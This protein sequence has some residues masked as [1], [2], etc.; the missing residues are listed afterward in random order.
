MPTSM[1][2]KLLGMYH[3]HGRAIWHEGDCFYASGLRRTGRLP[4]SSQ[5]SG[6]LA[7][8]E[9]VGVPGAFYAPGSRW[10]EVNDAC[11]ECVCLG[12]RSYTCAPRLCT[13]LFLCPSGLVPT[14]LAGDC[15]PSLCTRPRLRERT[16]F[17]PSGPASLPPTK[18]MLFA[19]CLIVSASLDSIL[20]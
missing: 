7:A 14:A 15:C 20:S 6:T 19:P 9:I 3:V 8:T 2:A 5:K 1:R 11:T 12:N 18:P 17:L 13:R 10:V 4:H 16:R